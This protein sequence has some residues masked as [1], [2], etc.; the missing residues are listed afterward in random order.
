[1]KPFTQLH[2]QP[3]AL[4]MS[5]VV[6]WPLQSTDPFQGGGKAQPGPVNPCT[7]THNHLFYPYQWLCH[8]RCS[9]LL[10]RNESH[11]G[12]VVQSV[13]DTAAQ[14]PTGQ[15][16]CHDKANGW[17][18]LAETETQIANPSATSTIYRMYVHKAHQMQT[19]ATKTHHKKRMCVCMWRLCMLQQYTCT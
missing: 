5:V 9:H 17:T 6:P 7:C 12:G 13:S 18:K 14:A 4:S 19:C 10:L 3:S 1:M 15:P 16:W 2:A 11:G 8:G